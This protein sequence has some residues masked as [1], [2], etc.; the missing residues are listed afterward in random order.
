ME[1]NLDEPLLPFVEVN[2]QA[3]GIVYEGISTICFNCGV[4]GHVKDQCP[5]TSDDV[6]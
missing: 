1:V 4:Y 2:R 3:Y 5:Y 6:V